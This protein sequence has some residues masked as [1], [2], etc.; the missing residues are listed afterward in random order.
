MDD[1]PISDPSSIPP[2]KPVDY[3]R[4]WNS[5]QLGLEWYEMVYDF[6]RKVHDYFLDWFS[7]A[8]EGSRAFRSVLEVGCGRGYPYAQLFRDYQY[9]GVDISQK[10]IEWCCEHYRAPNY[11]FWC[12]DFLSDEFREPS[13]LVFS[14]A[15]IDHVYDINRF[16]GRMV[17]SA[18][19]CVFISAYRGWFGGLERHRYQWMDSVT[20]FHNEVSPA[21]ARAALESLGCAKIEIFPVQVDNRYDRI[22][23][24]T[25]I[26]AHL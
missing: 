15:V 9:T 16:L 17:Q 8:G 5:N 19:Q 4:W 20:C 10:E 1:S 7:R 25:V 2:E 11:R 12:G 6:R 23:Q 13:D 3:G 14:H 24:E 18:N 22:D 26:I 21:E